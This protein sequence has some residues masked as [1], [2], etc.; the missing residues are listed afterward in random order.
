MSL[1]TLSHLEN[2]NGKRQNQMNEDIRDEGY[3]AFIDAVVKSLDA[4]RHSLV[5]SIEHALKTTPCPYNVGTEE[6]ND[7]ME[8]FNPSRQKRSMR[9]VVCA[10][11]RNRKTGDIIAGVR[12]WDE[13]MRAQVGD[14]VDGAE[15][16]QGFLDNKRRFMTRTE[17]WGVAER[18]HQIIHR[19]GG[20]TTNGGT[21][22]SENLY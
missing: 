2:W 16:E 22:Y 19:C 18:A 12:H 6:Y 5:C 11:C 9:K 17:A 20:D 14:D 21:L 4:S 7:W 10:A 1:G 8:G 3:K 15:W 13:I